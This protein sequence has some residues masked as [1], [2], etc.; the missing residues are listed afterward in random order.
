[1]IRKITALAAAWLFAS[2]ALGVDA[3]ALELGGGEEHT[4][5]LRIAVVD[6]WRDRPRPF[7]D[8]RFDGYWEFS[9]AVWDNPEESTAN[10]GATPVF[11]L[12]RGSGYVEGAIGFHLV[13]TRI[14]A[15][16]VFG[17][18]FQF[19]DHIG[20][21]FYFGEDRRFDLGLRLQHLSNA[22]IRHPNP[23]INF[24]LIRLQYRLDRPQKE[25]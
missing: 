8:W 6:F 5:L 15:E 14:S 1:M 24:V 19:G 2:P 21:G 9:A 17:T 7:G 13:Q 10:I 16:R 12:A 18:S 11:R 4:S 23:G 20:A 3:V 25:R 22:G